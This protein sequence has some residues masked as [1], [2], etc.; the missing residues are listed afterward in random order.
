MAIGLRIRR[1][2]TGAVLLDT[3]TSMTRMLGSV[4]TVANTAGALTHPGFATGIGF[5]VVNPVQA[6]TPTDTFPSASVDTNGVL[7]WTAATVPVLIVYGVH[8]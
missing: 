4:L 8:S 7:S 5:A 6:I 3:T 1:P 2:D